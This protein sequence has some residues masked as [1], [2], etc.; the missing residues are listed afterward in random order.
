MKSLILLFTSGLYSGYA[1]PASG[2]WGTA[3]AVLLYLPLA[4]WNRLDAVSIGLYLGVVAIVT[5]LAIPASTY[6]EKIH[7]EK[8]PGQITVDEIVGFF[9]TMFL[10]PTT[11]EWV[12]AGFFV[13]RAFDVLKPFPA[14]RLQSLPG[15]WG[16]VIDDLFAGLYSCLLLHAIRWALGVPLPA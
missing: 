14:H 10:L 4:R 6:A 7:G 9:A 16:V 11:V 5:A 13:F 8:D 1:R 12:A 15:G 2:T 3:V